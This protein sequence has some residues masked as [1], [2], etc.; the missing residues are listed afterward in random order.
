M[1]ERPILWSA[2]MVLALLAGRKTQTRRLVKCPST[3]TALRYV[4]DHE[5]VPAGRYTGWLVEC[6]AP[7]ALPLKAYAEVGER[8]WGRETWRTIEIGAPEA[9]R[10]GLAPGTDG[11]RFAADGTFKS[12]DATAAAA[13]LW[14]E[15]H[16]NGKHGV[17]WRPSIFMPRWA[18]RLRHEVTA[19]RVERLQDI[20]EA[21]AIAEGIERSGDE[22][23]PWS[24]PGSKSMWPTPVGCY[25][26]GWD[27]I[28]GEGSA[29]K[30]PWVWVVS[31][32]AVAHG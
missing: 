19:I 15:A 4:V 3:T 21:D 5:A 2:P 9:S 6:D 27:A 12:I 29:A 22:P 16:D 17:K 1:R 28:N 13:D 8:L 18:A 30:N 11:V 32:K 26:S 31:F 7:L 14:V 23:F 10:L 25:L 24:W 20:S